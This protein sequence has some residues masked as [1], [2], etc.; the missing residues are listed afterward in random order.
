MAVIVTVYYDIGEI[1]NRWYY[2]MILI[3]SFGCALNSFS[4]VASKFF[5][6]SSVIYKFNY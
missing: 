5:T 3:L 6:K 1:D 4:Y 2:S